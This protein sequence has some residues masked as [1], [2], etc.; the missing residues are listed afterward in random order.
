MSPKTISDNNIITL[1]TIQNEKAYEILNKTG[2]LVASEEFAMFE[3]EY[4]WIANQ[5]KEKGI[6][7][8]DENTK[9]PIWAWYKWSG[10]RKKMDMR[11]GG[12]AKRGTPLVQ[13]EIE[14]PAQ[15]VLLSD[16]DLWHYVLNKWPLTAPKGEIEPLFNQKELE[17]SWQ[18][19]FD[20][21]WA[22]NEYGIKKENQSIQATLWQVKLEQV[23]W[24]KHFVAK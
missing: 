4:T 24:I 20:L 11:E 12:F 22:V 21:G 9:Y 7:P 2:I 1:W 5:M 13:L 14:I 19:I 8:A 23:K 18:K 16:F 3:D 15:D 6:F 10:K 17:E